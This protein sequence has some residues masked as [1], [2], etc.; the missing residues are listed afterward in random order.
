MD[1]GHPEALMTLVVLADGTTSICFGHG[2]GIIGGGE[3][4]SVWKASRELS[5]NVGLYSGVLSPTKSFPYPNVGRVKFYVLT[6][7]GT[8]KADANEDELGIGRPLWAGGCTLCG[9]IITDKIRNRIYEKKHFV[10][11]ALRSLTPSE[12]NPAAPCRVAPSGLS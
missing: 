9:S 6:F 3:H 4:A 5:H 8:L 11:A 10:P 7:T 12:C 2:G 1:T